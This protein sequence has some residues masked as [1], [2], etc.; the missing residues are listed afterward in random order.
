MNRVYWAIAVWVIGFMGSLSQAWAQD[1]RAGV[2]LHPG[3]VEATVFASSKKGL[4]GHYIYNT[5]VSYPNALTLGPDGSFYFIKGSDEIIKISP[6]GVVSRIAEAGI[7]GYAFVTETRREAVHNEFAH[8]AVTRQGKI[9]TLY[10]G[11]ILI[12]ILPDGKIKFVPLKTEQGVPLPNPNNDGYKGGYPNFQYLAAG[13]D[14]QLYVST[15]SKLYSIGPDNILRP[16][17]SSWPR[18]TRDQRRVTDFYGAP[19]VAAG[20]MPYDQYG[21]VAGPDGYLY[22]T[23]DDQFNS[24]API[25]VYRIGPAGH[26]DLLVSGKT[27]KNLTGALAI[28]QGGNLYIATPDTIYKLSPRE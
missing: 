28:D 18:F 4:K 6:Q 21:V 16:V 17:S 25:N 2:V 7:Q 5:L 14:K 8:L 24:T 11:S 3:H 19:S 20:R 15:G 13:K 1:A 27:L 26:V 23:G 9:Y 22:G 10:Q 12:Q